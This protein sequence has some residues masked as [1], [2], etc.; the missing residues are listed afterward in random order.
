MIDAFN[1]MKLWSILI[2]FPISYHFKRPCPIY[3]VLFQNHD[4][5]NDVIYAL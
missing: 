2:D 5:V 3:K 1:F 4:L